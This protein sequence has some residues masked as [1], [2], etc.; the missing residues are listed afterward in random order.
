V[1]EAEVVSVICEHLRSQKWEVWIDDHS[2]H[3]SLKY[4]KHCLL[5]DGARPDIFGFNAVNQVY[6][7]EVKGTSDY[8][9]AIGQA[10]TYKSGVNLSYIGGLNTYLEKVSHTANSAGL[11]LIWVDEEDFTVK[12]ADPIFYTSPIFL[13]DVKNEL[14]VLQAHHKKFNRSFSSFSRTHVLNY[15]A[16]IFLFQDMDT[17][18]EE[19]LVHRFQA[20]KWKN[21]EYVE[22]ISGANTIGIL[23]LN[24][25]KYNLSKIGQYCLEHF[26]SLGIESISE[27]QEKVNQSGGRYKTVFSEFPTLAKFLQLIYF[28]N[29]DFKK[30]ISILQGFEK[31]KIS[32]REI[33]DKLILEFP[34]LF[35]NFFVKPTVKDQVIPQLISG[36]KRSLM[37]DYNKTVSDYGHYNFFFAF[38]R[39]LVHLGILDQKN[40][41][42]YGKSEDMDLENDYW[43]LGND[44]LI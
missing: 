29:P 18:T 20:V 6:A 24:K 36:K 26:K 37:E 15:F 12:I 11:G 19:Q 4:Q 8:K 30:F 17:K 39:H 3:K 14:S 9:K 7:V 34:N 31:R 28:Q 42:Y 38:K 5:I 21:K 25:E 2:I 23:D 41:A 33:L 40:T 43:I 32:S 44:I 35:L 22:L 27:F 13:N 1:N 10:L 16:P